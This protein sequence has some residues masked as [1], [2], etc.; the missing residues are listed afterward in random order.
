M[1]TQKS[2]NLCRET[3]QQCQ[4]MSNY[5][6]DQRLISAELDGIK[7]ITIHY[8][9]RVFFLPDSLKPNNLTEVLSLSLQEQFFFKIPLI[10]VIEELEINKPKSYDALLGRFQTLVIK[11]YQQHEFTEPIPH[12]FYDLNHSGIIQITYDG[13]YVNFIK[14][15]DSLISV[16][17]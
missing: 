12:S 14:L 10:K 5:Q 7:L 8:A 11:K 17:G 6:L 3:Q 9:T 1:E 15:E 13:I 4:D 16:I 2:I